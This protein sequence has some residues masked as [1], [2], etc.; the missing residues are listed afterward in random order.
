MIY[1]TPKYNT[2][3]EKL[4]LLSQFHQRIWYKLNQVP[5]LPSEKRY[6]LTIS[7]EKKFVWFRVPKV[8]TQ[9]ILHMFREQNIA[10]DAAQPYSCYYPS[11]VYKAYFKFA[12]VRNPWD[13]IVSCWQNKL[14]Q[15]NYFKL[16]E[17][18]REK[19]KDFSHFIQY[20]Q[21]AKWLMH[22]G[23]LTRQCNLID[24][25][26]VDFI[27]RY[28]TFESNISII[29]NRLHIEYSSIPKRNESQRE[30]ENYQ[31]Y[32]TPETAEVVS[33]M[34]AKDISMFGYKF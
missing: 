7:S 13:R 11:R 2:R 17:S 1:T 25:N 18:E 27:G 10:L 30:K 26:N 5:W 4:T 32:Y 19:M 9:T 15:D 21:E 22:D 24:L 8:G 31:E 3:S 20:L 34:Y 29:M 14:V 6:D 16:A 28:E 33:K 23:H 12:F